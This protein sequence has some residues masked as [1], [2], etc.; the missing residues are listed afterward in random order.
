[1]SA[2]NNGGPASFITQTDA[3]GRPINQAVPTNVVKVRS[4]TDIFL[5]ILCCFP[6]GEPAPGAAAGSNGPLLPLARPEFQNKQCLVLDLDETLVH[7]SFKPVPNPD[8][9]IPVEIEGKT[10]HVYVLKRPGV[11]EFLE[12]LGKLYE[13]VIFTA[14]LAKYA[15]PLLDL[16]DT[17]HV[18][19]HRLFRESCTCHEGNY[20]KDLKILG[21]PIERTII[22]DNSPMS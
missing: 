18:I 12:R 19:S 11:E 1:M 3:Q 10:H 17:H 22:V 4:T 5:R 16:L 13:I 21:R 6:G 20:V 7:S 14:S 2:R 15:D 8:Y 9:V